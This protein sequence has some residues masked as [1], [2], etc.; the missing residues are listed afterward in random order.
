MHKVDRVWVFER[1][2]H[3]IQLLASPAEVQLVLLPDFACKADELALDFDQWRDVAVSNFR[4]EMM[5]EE[6]SSL[7]A[8]DHS[9]SQLTDRGPQ[10]WTDDKLRTSEQWRNVRNLASAALCS[11]KWHRETPP[12]YADEFVRGGRST[13]KHK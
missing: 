11:F 4:P 7:E 10:Y 1:L 6:L 5:P 2:K 12:S 13:A 8:L 9:L 3:S